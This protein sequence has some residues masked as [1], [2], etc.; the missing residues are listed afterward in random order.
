VN[1][2]KE[3]GREPTQHEPQIPSGLDPFLLR[4]ELLELWCLK[5]LQMLRLAAHRGFSELAEPL[6]DLLSILEGCPGKQKGRSHTA[7]HCILMEFQAWQKKHPQFLNLTHYSLTLQAMTLQQRA[8]FLLPDQQLSFLD[9]LIDV[10]QLKS[11]DVALLQQ[12]LVRL[13]SLNLYKEAAMLSMKL[14]CQKELDLEE[15][16]V[17]L[18][19]Q[20]KLSLAE[21][22]VT[23]HSHL[24][25][26]L[27]TLLDSWCHPSFCLGDIRRRFP[28]LSVSRHCLDQIQPKMLTKHVFRLME[29]FNIDAGLCPNARHKRRLDSLRFLMYARFIERISMTEENWAAQYVVE[30]EPQLQVQLV[31]MLVKYSGL[32]KASQWSL[33]YSVPRD[34][35]PSELS[36]LLRQV[37]LNKSEQ[38]EFISPPSQREKFYQ[39]PLTEDK[40]VFVDTPEALLQCQK[41]VLK[42]GALVGVD[43]EWQPTFGCS[44]T[45][46][47]ALMQLAVMDQV[48]LLDISTEGFSQHS[49]TVSFIRSLFSSKNVLKL[50][51][52]MSGDLRCV[53][54]TWPQFSEEPLVT[55][56]VLDLV[57]VH[58]KI[59]HSK[60]NRTQTG[61]KEVLKGLSL[62]VQ[63]V[64]GRPLDK[65]EQMSN[66]KRRPLRASQIRYA[67]ADAYCLLEVYR[68]LESNPAHFGL[69][70]DLRDISPR[71]SEK[72][73]D[74]KPKEC[75]RAQ[76]V[77]RPHCD[78]EKDLLCGV[79]PS[80][81]SPPLPPQQLRVVCDNMLQGL[82]RTLRCLGVDVLM[83]ENGDDHRV[84]AKLAQ[85]EGR[86]ILTCGQPFLTLRSQVGE[87]RCLSLDCSEKAKDQA[88]R[89][90]R[91]FNVQP[92]PSDI[93]SRCQVSGVSPDLGVNQESVKRIVYPI[94]CQNASGTRG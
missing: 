57:H 20:N 61:S 75:Q 88:V 69:P 30:D 15:M 80:A 56:S 67:V 19:L 90:L 48:F 16:C 43:M 68:V 47:V 22:F 6:E 76:R 60:V 17:P 78:K 92:T 52:S 25:E 23:G 49:N 85:A 64:L 74:K 41:V 62:L 83:L 38:T 81:D 12:H 32:Q 31:Q 42:E 10:Y 45:Q 29:K 44:S 39:V 72:R 66:W 11:A 86:V 54:A 9:S 1:P 13:Q 8:L 2:G 35:L 40:I 27:V 87:G 3:R 4:E 26:R 70:D 24:E 51:Y 58:Q 94:W 73:K 7:G 63:Q 84:A 65:T 28:H 79:Q 71:Q 55:Q 5:D 33:K 82:G 46:Q 53:L 91:H 36:V 14:Q 59:Q 89:V 34:Q 21:S 50:G 37:D 93:F 18:I 77:S